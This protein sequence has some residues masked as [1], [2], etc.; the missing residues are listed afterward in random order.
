MFT[1]IFKSD[2]IFQLIFLIIVSIIIWIK[3]FFAVDVSYTPLN[4]PL[5]DLFKNLFNDAHFFKIILSFV[6]LLL[7]SLIFKKTLTSNDLT[8]KNSLLSAF[9]YILMMSSFGDFQSMQPLIFS[10]FFIIL[11]L[12]IMFTTYSKQESYEQIFI[13][14][15][16]IS[17]GSMFYFPLCFFIIFIWL[18]F[19]IFSLLKWR[20]WVISIL[21]F[22]TTYLF[23]FSFY[24]LTDDIEDK[25]NSYRIFFTET[26]FQIPHFP[27]STIIYFSILGVFFIF[28][29]S[30]TYSHLSERSIFYRKKIIVML[31]LIIIT[32]FSLFFS[33]AY[34][35]FHLCLFFIPFSYFIANYLLQIKKLYI[36][37]ILY[38][39]LFG[40]WVY[41]YLGF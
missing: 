9:L 1:K 17:L 28:S 21:G 8:P 40:I 7:Q 11:S 12:Q 27:I 14:T 16:L 29:F 20:E 4:A 5:Y 30:S 36:S 10:N 24:F 32:V 19:L 33:N 3:P 23:L 37:E 31:M 26:A 6:L 2:Y 25:L 22:I 18:I 41:T 35:V 13:A 38:L 15:F 39:L 34:F